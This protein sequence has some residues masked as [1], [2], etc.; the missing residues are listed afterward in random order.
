MCRY[1]WATNTYKLLSL[2]FVF[3]PFF[4]CNENV[5]NQN[6]HE[7]PKLISNSKRITPYRHDSIFTE[8]KTKL[9]TSKSRSNQNKNQSLSHITFSASKQKPKKKL[10]NPDRVLHGIGCDDIGI[11]VAD[12]GAEAI[13]EKA[14]GDAPLGDDLAAIAAPPHPG[15]SH[16]GLSVPLL[17]A[18]AFDFLRHGRSR[19]RR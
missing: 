1:S 9:G 5:V 17:E 12:V 18:K 6:T 16:S 4:V 3:L 15:D 14:D 13:G 7:N 10:S 11:V 2:F 8:N 19:R